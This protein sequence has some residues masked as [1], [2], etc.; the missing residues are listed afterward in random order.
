MNAKIDKLKK[1]FNELNKL[2]PTKYKA[3]LKRLCKKL[4]ISYEDD[5]DLERLLNKILDKLYTL[6][7]SKLFDEVLSILEI[8]IGGL[9]LEQA[10]DGLG[11]DL[12]KGSEEKKDNDQGLSL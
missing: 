5:E 11:K 12:L 2:N 1:L 4:K 3:L 7:D 6:K 10:V 9:K 8:E